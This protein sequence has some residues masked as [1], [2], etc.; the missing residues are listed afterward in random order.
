MEPAQRLLSL[1]TH[2]TRFEQGRGLFRGEGCCDSKGISRDGIQLAVVHRECL[3]DRAL[4][5]HEVLHA[6]FG[7]TT[8]FEIVQKLPRR[9]RREPPQIRAGQLQGQGVTVEVLQEL[10]NPPVRESD[11]DPRPT[12]GIDAQPQ[13]Q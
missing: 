8:G 9:N 13:G 5:A 6:L 7:S 2:S 1:R 3:L 12:S 11:R 10:V 4:V